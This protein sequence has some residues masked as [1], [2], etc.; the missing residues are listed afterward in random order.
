VDPI[1][2]VALVRAL[3]REGLSMP[4]VEVLWTAYEY[5]SVLHRP[6]LERAF[7]VPVYTVYAA[8]DLGGGC[9]AFRCARGHFHVRQN[10]YVFEFLRRGRPVAP[11]ELGEIAVT[12]LYHRYMPLIRYRVEDLA[13]PLGTRCPC[14]HGDWPAFV[15]EGRLR[16]CMRDAAGQVVT[17]RAFDDLFAG[18]SWIDFYQMTQRSPRDY[19]LL[20]VRRPGTDEAEEALFRER[21]HALLGSEARLRVRYVREIPTERSFKFRLTGGALGPPEE[22]GS[23]A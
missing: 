19:E 20:A 16:D 1:Y 4:R 21:A 10:Q 17:T 23:D 9:Q 15:L 8:T 2:A 5:C 11:G 6:V 22:F 7:G 18:L 12:S 13:R 14:T 3:E